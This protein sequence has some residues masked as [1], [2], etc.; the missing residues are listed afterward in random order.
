MEGTLL[1]FIKKND[2]KKGYFGYIFTLFMLERNLH[3][4]LSDADSYLTRVILRKS[5]E[6]FSKLM[7]SA[8]DH[9]GQK[10]LLHQL[11]Q[12]LLAEVF[13]GRQQLKAPL[14]SVHHPQLAV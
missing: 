10:G 5:F 13:A 7:S 3:G 4:E 12:I 11:P 14:L 2:E 1:L 9:D 8:N 6:L